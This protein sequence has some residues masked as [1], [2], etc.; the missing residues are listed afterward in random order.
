M[1]CMMLRCFAAILLTGLFAT[2]A[3]AEKADLSEL[4]YTPWTKFC[5]KENCF[6]GRDGH[7]DL[8]VGRSYRLY[9]LRVPKI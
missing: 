5:L 9:S 8:T 2:S 4:T 7:S 3:A 6:I 1:F